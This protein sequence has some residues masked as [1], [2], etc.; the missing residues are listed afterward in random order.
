MQEFVVIVEQIILCLR[1]VSTMHGAS[2]ENLTSSVGTQLISFSRPK[3][4]NFRPSS[5][6]TR[7]SS[8]SGGNAICSD[9]E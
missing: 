2:Q 7:S 1:I 4:L 3:A 5:M 8:L 6:M 9:L